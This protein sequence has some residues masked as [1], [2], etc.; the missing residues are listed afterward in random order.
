MTLKDQLR[1][2]VDGLN[3]ENLNVRPCWKLKKKKEGLFLCIL[4][5]KILLPMLFIFVTLIC[6]KRISQ[7]SK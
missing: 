5:V 7:S 1:D 6:V 2:V 4:E 3:H